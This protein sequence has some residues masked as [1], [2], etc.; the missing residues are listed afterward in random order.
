MATICSLLVALEN[1]IDDSGP[2][3]REYRSGSFMQAASYQRLGCIS[4]QTALA[5]GSCLEHE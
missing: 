1:G 5:H 4:S 2:R 3:A